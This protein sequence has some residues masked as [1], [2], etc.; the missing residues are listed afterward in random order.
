MLRRTSCLW[1]L[2]LSKDGVL[3]D[4]RDWILLR[5]TQLL[6][7]LVE[8]EFSRGEHLF[9]LSQLD[10]LNRQRRVV[11]DVWDRHVLCLSW[12]LNDGVCGS[13]SLVQHSR[14]SWSGRSEL[15]R[16]QSSFSQVAQIRSNKPPSLALELTA[17]D[18]QDSTQDFSKFDSL[19]NPNGSL[20]PMLLHTVIS[21]V[22]KPESKGLARICS[23]NFKGEASSKRINSGLKQI[24]GM[25]CFHCS[26]R[27]SW[28]VDLTTTRKLSLFSMEKSFVKAPR[29]C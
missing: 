9:L 25:A 13:V 23:V 21:S 18:E 24:S 3:S 8:L 4:G 19:S 29:F 12:G 7:F 2:L 6:Q 10:F 20:H 17:F 27:N 5:R 28:C 15:I 26:V 22:T 16:D 11:A 1:L 14:G